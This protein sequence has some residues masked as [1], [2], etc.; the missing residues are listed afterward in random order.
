M[1]A[2]SGV[3]DGMTPSFVSSVLSEPSLR[4]E[5]MLVVPVCPGGGVSATSRRVPAVPPPSASLALLAPVP[6]APPELELEAP[7]TTA[8]ALPLHAKQAKATTETAAA[9]RVMVVL[10]DDVGARWM[11]PAIR[12]QLTTSPNPRSR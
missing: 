4:T 9:C 3:H 7:G 2:P 10:R 5:K 1:T 11:P 12:P 6:P 8:A